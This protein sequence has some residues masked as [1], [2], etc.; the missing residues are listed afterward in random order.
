LAGRV[1]LHERVSIRNGIAG[2]NELLCWSGRSNKHSENSHSKRTARKRIH[3][4]Q[5]NPKFFKSKYKIVIEE[6]ALAKPS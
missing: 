2:N 3:T 6:V 4:I 1:W 5:I